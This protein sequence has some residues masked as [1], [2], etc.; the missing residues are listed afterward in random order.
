MTISIDP[1]RRQLRGALLGLA[2]CLAWLA[3]TRAVAG[4]ILLYEVG[5]A[6]VGLAS[7]GLGAR[8]QDASTVLTNPA[9]MARLEGTHLL[10]GAQVLHAD[11]AFTPDAGTSPGLGTGGGGNPV[12]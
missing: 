12:G 9:G 3:P 11:L 10:L 7:A 1:A 6:D 8:A 4:G 2:V 5:S